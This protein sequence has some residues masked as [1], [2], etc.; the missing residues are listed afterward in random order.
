MKNLR[1]EMIKI[2]KNEAFEGNSLDEQC[3]FWA[4]KLLSLFKQQM[5]EITGDRK[6][7]EELEPIIPSIFKDLVA[8]VCFK[9][10]YNAK[11]KE[12]LKNIEGL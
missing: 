12:L 7:I 3:G 5:K 6:S 1:E 9:E 2:L 11:T 4:D 10:G 8:K